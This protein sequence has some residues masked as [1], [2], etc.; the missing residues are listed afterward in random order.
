MST[1]LILRGA[2]TKRA[3]RDALEQISR[4]SPLKIALGKKGDALLCR[5]DLAEGDPDTAALR[6]SFT[7]RRVQGETRRGAAALLYWCFHR[8]AA[9]LSGD[10]VDP[11]ED[12]RRAVSP[13]P[14]RFFE[15][16]CRVVREHE[17][18]V[19][20]GRPYAGGG[21]EPPA[22]GTR[23]VAD[24]LAELVRSGKLVLATR[25]VSAFLGLRHLDGEPEDLYE[26]LLESEAVEELFLSG[27]E[28][29][30]QLK[31][32]LDG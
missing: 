22:E 28:F 13:S 32:F 11:Q 2:F 19:M 14:E 9:Q 8:L 24:F 31:A 4:A 7:S 6:I 30:A 18:E 27:R 23:T 3:F 15:E 12:E 1:T 29:E 26:E 20:A 25:D 5:L 10:L 17:R 21:G 16:A